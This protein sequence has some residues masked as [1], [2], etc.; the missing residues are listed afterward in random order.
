MKLSKSQQHVVDLMDQGWHL[1]MT[2]GINPEPWLQ[3]DGLGYGGPTERIHRGTFWAL[4]KKRA[5]INKDSGYRYGG[6]EYVLR[7]EDGL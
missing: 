7:R 6:T 3:R 2:G 5:I 1:G 4:W